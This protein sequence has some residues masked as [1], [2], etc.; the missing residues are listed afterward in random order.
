MTGDVVDE[1]QPIVT[2]MEN[3]EMWQIQRMTVQISEAYKLIFV[4]TASKLI[5]ESTVPLFCTV[6]D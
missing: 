3:Y 2:F 6:A 4:G 5:A 1:G